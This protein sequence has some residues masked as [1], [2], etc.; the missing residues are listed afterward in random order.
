VTDLRPVYVL[1]IFLVSALTGLILGLSTLVLTS[2]ARVERP[3]VYGAGVLVITTSITWLIL[4]R[5]GIRILEAVLDI[6]IDQDGWI[7]NPRIVI[8]DQR[9]ESIQQGWILHELPGGEGKFAELSSGVM[10]GTPLAERY[11]TGSRGPYSLTE[12]RDLR[13]YLLLRGLLSWQNEF[14]HRQGLVIKPQG[15]ALIRHYAEYMQSPSL[16]ERRG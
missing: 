3:W 1:V 16:K 2:L 14:D 6:D 5:R 15:R 13:D 9:D 12:F 8:M 10:N 7:G 4:I 11:W